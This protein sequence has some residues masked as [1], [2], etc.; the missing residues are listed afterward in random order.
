MDTPNNLTAYLLVLATFRP[1][2]PRKIAGLELKQ[3]RVFLPGNVQ[4]APKIFLDFLREGGILVI[5][6]EVKTVFLFVQTSTR[7]NYAVLILGEEPCHKHRFLTRA[8]RLGR[9]FCI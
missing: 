1:P 2:F 7:L 8:L 6:C 5:A 4:F 9:L 3:N